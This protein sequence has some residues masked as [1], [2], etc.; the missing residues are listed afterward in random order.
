MIS[1]ILENLGHQPTKGQEE[2][3][4]RLTD[5]LMDEH[6]KKAFMVKG[7]A[8]TGK[9][10]LISAVV[11]TLEF[12]KI[13]SLL[14]A[15]TG[16]AAKVFSSYAGKP[17]YTIHRKIYRQKSSTDGFGSFV[18]NKNLFSNLVILVDEASMISNNFSEDSVFG[19]GRLLEDLISFVRDG[20]QCKLVLIGDTAQLPPVGIN[21]SP[22]LDLSELS[23]HIPVAGEYTLTDIVRQTIHSGI[24]QNATKLRNQITGQNFTIPV[25]RQEGFNDIRF[26]DGNELPDLLD[27]TYREYGIEENIILCRSNKKAN[28]YNAGI[29]KQVLFREEEL[30]KDDLFMVVKNNYHWVTANPDIEFIANG[31]ILRLLKVKKYEERYGFRF[32][33]ALFRL[34]DYNIEFEAWILLD[35]LTSE[36]ASLSSEDN[37]KLYQNVLE[38]YSHI[39]SRSKQYKLVKEDPFFNALQ[40]KY[41]YA[42]TCH[43]AQGGQ[44]KAV[45]VDQGYITRERIDME[46]LR[47]LYTAVTR[48]TEKLYLVNFSNEQKT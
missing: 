36:S 37:R 12:W 7:Y 1:M 47:W 45:Y 3:I 8:G 24:L 40:V 32:A 5:F 42:I 43:K 22:A 18:L 20:N 28:Q 25:F 19:S 39:E 41:A 2:L 30:E 10:T 9:T 31:D 46:Y 15:P 13:K 21:L 34:I 35:T 14:L 6:E 48:A 17:A 26:A 4:G 38:D 29:R 44:W 11:R 27:K 33:F 16:R 23:H